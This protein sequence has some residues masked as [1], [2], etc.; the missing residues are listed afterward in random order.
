[1]SGEGDEEFPGVGVERIKK[2]RFPH[3]T[4]V[5]RSTLSADLQSWSWFYSEI[6]PSSNSDSFNSFHPFIDSVE[7]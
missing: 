1:M 3:I 6:R 5:A 4:S 2:V 7:F